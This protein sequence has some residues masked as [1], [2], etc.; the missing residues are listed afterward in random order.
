LN[1]CARLIVTIL[2]TFFFLNGCKIPSANAWDSKKGNPTHPTH[3]YLTEW[4]I[5]QLNSQYT[6]L[7]QYRTQV[8]EGANTE[9]HELPVQGS[10]YGT[11]LDAKRIKHQGTN[12]GCN[13]IQGWWQD[14]LSA[15][16]QNHKE[17]SYFILGIML[18]MIEDMGVPAH[19]NKVYHQGNLKE[20]DNF[21]FMALLNW[22]PDFANINRQDPG[23]IDP[24][25]YY[26]FSQEWAHADA[27]NYNNRSSFSKIWMFASRSE[28]QLLSNRQGRTANVVKW[29]TNSAMT[30]FKK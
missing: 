25:K 19:A 29:A 28:R 5:D 18:H 12:E 27:P 8:V 20:F 22:K 16:K 7:Q 15:Y 17:Q 23:Y 26:A 10:M 1:T 21:E 11:N 13:D 3:S 24:W 30:A 6:E 4:A 2:A 9:L 14:S